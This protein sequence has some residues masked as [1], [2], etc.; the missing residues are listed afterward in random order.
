[1]KIAISGAHGQGKTTIVNSLKNLQT[2]NKYAYFESPTRALQ[3]TLQINENGTQDTQVSIM[4]KH[5]LNIAASSNDSIFDRCALDG[6]VYTSYFKHKIHNTVFNSLYSLYEYMIRQ[7]D[8]VFY[9]W[10]ELALTDDGTRSQNDNFFE[11]IK[12]IFGRLVKT[13]PTKT[14][15]LKG[16][17]E[18]R[19]ETILQ[20][21][22]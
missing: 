7:Y 2:F 22:N 15:I 6:I 10:P 9:I 1:M 14:V 17:N 21:I 11:Q 8:I 13:C 16:S 18:Q 5:Y 20:N 4:H 12:F 19:I 3:G